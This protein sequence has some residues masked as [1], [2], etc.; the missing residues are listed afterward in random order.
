VTLAH[1]QRVVP[2]PKFDLELRIPVPSPTADALLGQAIVPR[3][4][5][6][7]RQSQLGKSPFHSSPSRRVR[8][9][10]RG[11]AIA[12][13]VGA[14][15]VLALALTLP[16]GWTLSHHLETKLDEELRGQM[17][18]LAVLYGERD[19]AA[20]VR[21]DGG[22]V[23]RVDVQALPEFSDHVLVDHVSQM[24]GGVATVFVWDDGKG[25]FIRRT[26]SVKKEDGSRAIGTPLGAAHPAF[27]ALKAGAVYRGEATLFGKPYYTEYDPVIGPGGKV[28]GALFIGVEQA[29]FNG[30]RA[31]VI[32][33]LAIGS[34]AALVVLAIA[35]SVAFGRL[36]RPLREV[37]AA[38]IGLTD[39]REDL[40]VPHL[41][42]NDDVGDLAR[43]VEQ[44]RQA[45]ARARALETEERAREA[46][47][48][49][50]AEAVAAA[51]AEFEGCAE[52]ILGVVHAAS[53]E[54]GQRA[55]VLRNAA[56]V[57]VSRLGEAG[58]AAEDAGSNVTAVAGAAEEFAAS[59]GEI[60]QQAARSSEIA[61]RAVAEAEASNERVRELSLAA[62]RIGEVVSLITAIAEQTNLLALNATIEAARAGDAGRGFAVVASEVKNL[63]TQTAHATED[64]RAQIARMQGATDET[65]RAIA[66][67]SDTIAAM[68]KIAGAIASAVDQQNV[69]TREIA[70]NVETAAERSSASRDIL[71]HVDH[72]AADTSGAAEAV[73]KAAAAMDTEAK[74]LAD[75]IK[76]F[77]RRVEAA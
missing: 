36:F 30:V 23:R 38:I 13:L 61:N 48:R 39:G 65:V 41:A 43:A 56:Q 69:T 15:T 9:N 11:K 3:N 60:S 77:T 25:D 67:I 6:V 33:T 75:A 40:T 26:T 32:G 20:A 37:E 54:L 58:R 42:R 72:A 1:R 4:Q 12:L 17:R 47:H 63:A 2:S 19:P 53:E 18:T 70:R 52:D 62:H 59:I 5:A 29:Y 24:T 7:S 73:T 27:A 28:V 49:K 14:L 57:T 44:F 50:R 74:K 71:A 64:I 22:A 31:A 76:V 46:A 68:Q 66:G 35:A 21:I 45:Q 34:L 16:A 55:G 10:L 51:V 8:L